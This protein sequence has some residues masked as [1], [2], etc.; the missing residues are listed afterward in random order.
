MPRVQIEQEGFA[1]GFSDTLKSGG[2]PFWFEASAILYDGKSILV[3]HDKP[4]PD[5]R[6]SIGFWPGI[7]EMML[8]PPAYFTDDVFKRGIKYEELAQTPD[9]KWV[10][11]TTAFDRVKEGSTDWDGYNLLL[12]WPAGKPS[13]AQV[14][15][16]AQAF[17]TEGTSVS[18]RDK[19]SSALALE[20][21][22]FLGLVRYFKIEGLTA[23]AS[24]LYVGIREEGNSFQDF[25]SVVRIL[26]IPYT[27]VGRGDKQHIELT[28]NF[29]PM[30]T[31]KV[32]AQSDEKLPANLGLSSLKYDPSRDIFWIITS[33]E[34]STNVGSYLWTA[35]EAELTAGKMNI[36]RLP[37]NEPLRMTHKAEDMTFLNPRTVLLINDDDRLPTKMY[38]SVRKP[39]Q[40]AY[41]VLTVQ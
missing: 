26:T 23:T 5:G 24:Q 32:D 34:S 6:S 16:N 19:L 1:I 13:K 27:V 8:N 40:A 39:N 2:K 12:C 7:R 28:G 9:R 18:L 38:N 11:A 4:M 37:N 41:L 29:T 30:A 25:K 22:T 21:L 3:A 14:L 31:I 33:H 20:D 17:T 10:F 36:V 35:T 15:G